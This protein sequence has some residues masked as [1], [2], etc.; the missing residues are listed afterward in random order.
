MS[1]NTKIIKTYCI[2]CAVRCPVNC[3]VEDGKFVRVTPDL[4]HPLGGPFCPKGAAAPE[5]V[6][7]P[8]RLKYP[9]KRTS[10]KTAEDPGWT[11]IS[12]DEALDTIAAKMSAAQSQHGAE[13][14]VFYRPA[15]GGSPS[16]DYVS[17]MFRLA[18]AFGSPNTAATTHICNWHR[19]TGSAY[20]YGVGM[21]EADY[22]NAG[23]IIIW[24]TN[25][26]ATGVRHVAPIKAAVKRGAKLIVIDPRRI[27][28]VNQAAHWLQVRPGADLAL[29]L[30]LINQMI[31]NGSH[32]AGFLS[33][34]TNAPFLLRDDTGGLLTESDLVAGGSQTRYAVWDAADRRPAIYDPEQVGFEPEST[35]P[36]LDGKVSVTLGDGRA[37]SCTTVFAKLKEIA[38]GYT[39]ERT[40]ELTAIPAQ[41]IAEAARTIGSTGPVC[42]YTYNGLEQHSDA[43]QTNRAVCIL[44]ALT[45]DFDRKG[46]VVIYP[47]LPVKGVTG[48]ALLPPG[49]AERRLGAEKRPLGP[50]GGPNKDKSGSI[51]AYEIYNAITTGQP[52]PVK[53]LIS[54]GG[55]LIVSNG[56]TLSGA[57]ALRQLDFF[58]QMDC[59][60]NPTARFADILLP[61]ASAW[62]SEL[63]GQHK[64]RDKGQLQMRRRIVEPEYERR[65]DLDVIFALAVRLGLDN[66]FFGGDTEAAFNEMLAPLGKTVAEIRDMPE[67]M[68]VSLTPAYR[69]FA[70][71]DAASGRPKGFNTPCR[72]I[73]IYS[74]TF[75]DHGYDPLPVYSE[76]RERNVDTGKFPLALTASKPGAFTHGSYRSI[77][78]LRTLVP[79][80]CLEINPA[81]ARERGIGDGDWVALATPK[82]AIRVKARFD[83]SIHPGVVSG[84]EG[85]WQGCEA[86]DLPGYD[87]FDETGANLN[88]LVSNDLIDPI[89]G[90]VPHRGHPCQVSR[91]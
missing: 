5:F 48:A 80:P 69:K 63:L 32:D 18:N 31:E 51:Q 70:E 16:R 66:V 35:E 45:G 50:A 74:T 28:L 26:H 72:L 84:Q 61:A 77:P 55:N 30:G 8:E 88:L 47:P 52:Y 62:E 40:A 1:A 36:L 78:S 64:W 22:D 7:D 24:G 19:D 65:S 90:S 58:V 17:W 59:Y 20:T 27:P 37:V 68:P 3:H 25:P 87:P 10:P 23:S 38:S 44:Y 89:S 54:F 82:G 91:L 46:G 76:P 11:R 39:V 71:T 42:Y 53:A 13:S 14:V 75:A 6:Y 49:I 43:M 86:L 29:A 83:D 60:E 34:W 9:M 79:E 4:D 57:E 33:R 67:G 56:D 41:T 12:W 21:P 73:E 81:T 2:M 85:W 15:P